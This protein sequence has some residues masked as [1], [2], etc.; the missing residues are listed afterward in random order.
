MAVCLTRSG[1][2][3]VLYAIVLPQLVACGSSGGSGSSGATSATSATSADTGSITLAWTAPVTRADGEPMSL[4]EIG[5]TGGR[6]PRIHVDAT[7][8]EFRERTGSGN[9][10]VV[11]LAL[12]G[13]ELNLG[14]TRGIRSRHTAGHI[15]TV[16]QYP[17]DAAALKSRPP[18]WKNT[19]NLYAESGN[20][21]AEEV[22]AR[23]GDTLDQTTITSTLP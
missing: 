23:F 16:V 14:V 7:D 1:L 3:I 6:P 18:V 8:D 5:G 17:E 22:I 11:L 13:H 12:S 20:G 15:F 9:V 10:S 4:A 21:F 19:W 2:K